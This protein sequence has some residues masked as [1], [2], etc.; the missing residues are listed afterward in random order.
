MKKYAIFAVGLL[1]GGI[2]LGPAAVDATHT[3]VPK[4]AILLF[5]ADKA[6]PSNFK[7]VRGLN[8]GRFPLGGLDAGKS[9][10]KDT[11]GGTTQLGVS[12]APVAGEETFAPYQES[13][14]GT[15]HAHEV[16]FYRVRFC[17]QT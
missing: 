12:R 2:L 5:E 1:V 10:R 13:E 8:V 14:A 15:V 4:G 16:P 3:G 9:A 11:T 7:P 17:K 6:C